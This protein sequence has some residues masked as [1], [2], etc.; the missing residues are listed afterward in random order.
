MLSDVKANGRNT[1]LSGRWLIAARAAWAITALLILSVFVISLPERFYELSQDPYQFMPILEQ[2]GLD[3][4]IAW[5]YPNLMEILMALACLTTAV[6]IF[7]LKRD[8][9]LGLLVSIALLFFITILPTNNS[10]R[11]AY[12][13]LQMPLFAFRSLAFLIIL[14]VFYLFPDGHFVP[15][16]TRGL[17]VL[18]IV[19]IIFFLSIPGFTIAA[20]P[21]DLKTKEQAASVIT[22]LLMLS[23]GVFAQVH[24]YGRVSNMVQRQQTKWVV[25]GFTTVFAGL[26][27]VS[28]PVVLFP[29]ILTPGI[30]RFIYFVIA[31]PIS[32]LALFALPLSLTFS[33]LKYHLWDIDIIVRRTLVYGALTI[34]LAVV[35]FGGVVLLQELFQVMTGQH[36]SPIAIVIST[37]AIAALFSSLRQRIQNGIDRRFYRQKYDAEKM[38][39]NFANTARDEVELEKLVERL[40]SV[41]EETLKPEHVS[42]WLHPSSLGDRSVPATP[43]A[44]RI[45]SPEDF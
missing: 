10:L 21:I 19:T 45:T 41:V 28:V 26:A 9:W 4:R 38:L 14:I 36:Q 40:L 33:I 18:W 2:L 42:L 20:A 16:W 44:A 15:K 7:W 30:A 37:L 34:T 25:F 23:T 6:I 11:M 8:D 5:V 43:T 1:R 31:V 29:V 27:L 24:R 32:L 39:K 3:T 17:V 35:Y 22:L 12:P 13:A